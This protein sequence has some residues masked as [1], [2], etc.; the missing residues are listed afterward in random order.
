MK[1]IRKHQS[2]IMANMVMQYE[3]GQGALVMPP[4]VKIIPDLRKMRLTRVGS[5]QEN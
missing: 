1:H 5:R 3:N 2:F 4:P